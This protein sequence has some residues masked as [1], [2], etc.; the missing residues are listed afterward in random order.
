MFLKAGTV[1]QGLLHCNSNFLKSATMEIPYEKNH[2]IGFLYCIRELLSS[3]EEMKEG[4]FY[5]FNVCSIQLWITGK[6]K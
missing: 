1:V 6:G 4:M 5:S 3:T 2:L